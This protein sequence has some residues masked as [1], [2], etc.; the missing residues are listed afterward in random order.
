MYS[1]VYDFIRSVIFFLNSITESK[2][3]GEKPGFPIYLSP[4]NGQIQRNKY[5]L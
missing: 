4:K 1:P 3:F 5:D 2:T